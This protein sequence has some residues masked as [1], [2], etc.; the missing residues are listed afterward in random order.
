MPRR[1][2]DYP[3]GYI[4]WNSFITFGTML[5]FISLIIFMYIVGYTIFNPR[6]NQINNKLTTR[7]V[8]Y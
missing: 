2:P 6:T 5:T 8:A 4:G 3:D 7:W 1:I